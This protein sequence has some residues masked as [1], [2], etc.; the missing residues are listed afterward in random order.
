MASAL[1]QRCGQAQRVEISRKQV[2]QRVNGHG[3][4]DGWLAGADETCCSASAWTQDYDHKYNRLH[5]QQQAS[6][7]AITNTHLKQSRR[8]AVVLSAL[9]LSGLGSLSIFPTCDR[10]NNS[11][12]R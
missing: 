8:F 11:I 4:N 10:A 3:S 2:D 5:D 12:A 1:P 9:L 7:M 6:E